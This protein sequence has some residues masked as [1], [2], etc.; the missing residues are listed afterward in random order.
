MNKLSLLMKGGASAPAPLE[1]DDLFVNSIYIGTTSAS[2]NI[3]GVDTTAA[4]ALVWIKPRTAAVSGYMFDTIR[5]ALAGM[6]TSTTAASASIT[7]SVTAFLNSGFT[8]GTGTTLSTN[9]AYY[10]AWSMRE[11]DNFFNM[12]SISHTTGTATNVDLTA[13]GTIGFVLLKRTDAVGEWWALHRQNTVGN[14]M[15]FQTT[16]AQ[17]TTTPHLSISGTTLTIASG[18]ATGTYMVYAWAHDTSSDGVIQCGSYTGNGSATTG[19]KVTL[20]WEPQWILV[21]RMNSTGNWSIIDN[22]R[23]WTSGSNQAV[24]VNTAS[25]ETITS[26]F[27]H[28]RSD[29]FDVRTTSTDFNANGGTYCYVAIRRPTRAPTSGEQV[30]QP[31]V[32]TGTST[33]NQHVSVG[34]APDMIWLRKRGGSGSGYEGFVA[35][36]RLRG[37]GFIKTGDN[38]IGQTV[39]AAG[40]DQMIIST[41]EYG[42]AFTPRGTLG[43]GTQSNTIWLGNNAGTTLA[44]A[45]VNDTSTSYVAESFKRYPKFMD[46]FEYFGTG[47]AKSEKHNLTVAPELLICRRNTT[48]GNWFVWHKDFIDYRYQVY[49][50]LAGGVTGPFNDMTAAPD[51]TNVYLGST[52]MINMSGAGYTCVLFATLAGISKVGSYV[53]N[54]TTQNIECGF[55][56]G[57]RFLL[58]KSTG[59]GAWYVFDSA[60]GMTTGSDP[61]LVTSNTAA[62]GS[63]DL[64]AAYAGGFQITSGSPS[65]NADGVTYIFLAIA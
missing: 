58:V 64:L 5:G 40:L 23:G 30:F 26:T 54:G 19:L 48:G 38:S 36:F 8:I 63:A 6:L 61:Y 51:A 50:E 57:A 29:G 25:A 28:L 59:T 1:I 22:Q 53:G 52:D 65:L 56:A 62:E 44:S 34:V 60:R 13:L 33:A 12:R 39:Q 24:V 11:A 37:Q 15:R 47:A 16:A 10:A 4:N 18:Q 17:S 21:K 31:T 41:T 20:G 46:I 2:R 32:Y 14:N 45:N 42:S 9:S 3:P 55:S 27:A 49:L 43:N 7:G 35:G